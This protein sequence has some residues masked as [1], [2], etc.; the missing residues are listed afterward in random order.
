MGPVPLEMN[1]TDVQYDKLR[2]TKKGTKEVFWN[3]F[4]SCSGGPIGCCIKSQRFCHLAMSMELREVVILD[5]RK[6]ESLR[7]EQTGF[8]LLP[9][10]SSVTDWAQ[11]PADGSE[12]QLVFSAELEKVIRELHP[13]VEKVT[14]ASFL[15][16]GGG[17]NPP[18]TNGLHLDMYP[19]LGRISAFR[20]GSAGA[21]SEEPEAG[22]RLGLVLGLWMP[23]EMANPVHDYPFFFGDMSTFDLTD[24]VAQKQDFYQDAAGHKQRVRNIAASAP[25]YSPAQRW[26]YYSQ[27]TC[28][29]VVIFRHLTN[30]PG[31]K[32]SFHAAFEQPLPDGME[33]RKSVETRAFLYFKD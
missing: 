4:P 13:T 28:D 1:E 12:Q 22:L 15:L 30:P 20:Q 5:A 21:Q 16:R 18:A 27:Q 24:V 33:S 7:Y 10:K 19:D 32:A 25:V 23:R 14:F 26:Y 17:A 6:R 3:G 2:F 29:E 31:G 11:V 9:L 8:T